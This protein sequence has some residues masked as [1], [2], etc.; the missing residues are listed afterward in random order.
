[1]RSAALLYLVVRAGVAGALTLAAVSTVATAAG[2]TLL[3]DGTPALAAVGSALEVELELRNDG[4]QPWQPSAG[5]AVSYHLLTADGATVEWDGVRTPLAAAVAVGDVARVRAELDVPA[6]AGEYRVVWD[7]VEEHVR[8][9]S[10]GDDTPQRGSPLTVR[11]QHAAAITAAAPRWLL[12]GRTAV[13]PVRVRN[14]GSFIWPSDGSVAVAYHWR[15]LDGTEVVWDGRRTP[16]PAAVAPGA[17]VSLAALV[18]APTEAG[19]LVLEW[20][21]VHEGVAWFSERDPEPRPQSVVRIV[22]PPPAVVVA[23]LLGTM[24]AVGLAGWGRRR[25]RAIGSDLVWLAVVTVTAPVWVVAAAGEH[26]SVTAWCLSSA[27]AALL[28]A[29]LVALPDGWRRWIVVIVGGA[30]L[31][32]AAGDV[33]HLRFFGDLPSFASVAAAGQ[34]DEVVASIASLLR[35]GDMWLAA[36][37]VGGVIIALVRPAAFSVRRRQRVAVLAAL[38]TASGITGSVLAMSRGGGAVLHQVFRNIYV[39]RELGTLPYHVVDGAR[40]AT[41]RWRRGHLDDARKA[42]LVGWFRRTMPRRAGAGASFGALAGANLVMIQVESLQTF[43]VG[44]E[45]GGEPVMPNLARWRHETVFAAGLT[46]QTAGGRSSDAELATQAS[47]LPPDRGT[48]V[49]RYAGNEFTG[50]AS[51]LS[52]HGYATL[53]AVPFDG[54]FW[55]RRNTHR[56]WGY[57]TTLFANAFGDGPTVGWGLNDRDFLLQAA[58]RI[59]VLERPFCAWLL[60]LS[61]HHPFEGFPERFKSLDV[62]ALDGTPFGNYLHTMHWLDGA[63]GGLVERLAE[64]GLEDTT[65]VAVWGDHDA[66]FEWTPSLAA[67]IGWPADPAGWYLSQTVPLFIRVPPGTVPPAALD[68]PAGHIDV[69][70]TLLALLGIDPAPYALVGRNLLGDPGTGPV[71]G[72]YRCWRDARRLFLQGGPQLGDGQCRLL[73]GLALLPVA[74]C[75]PGYRE[76][77]RRVEVSNLVLTHDLQGEVHR[78]LAA[79]PAAVRR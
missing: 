47:L 45:V 14:R 7:V 67:R 1:M 19:R 57:R 58:D 15:R 43:V 60:T 77:M 21:L 70:P 49:F 54:G 46:D 50:L 36:M 66:G 64:L 76:A 65:V 79:E 29:A 32:V 38:A 3:A 39:A 52:E 75:A 26:T 25:R 33:L 78:V 44:M 23:G 30:V 13:V 24:I 48:A 55:N 59:A 12:V 17:E 51:I 40:V 2:L 10:A 16:L 9:V 22:T 74:E 6:V 42:R 8:W 18:E 68:V 28:C 53:S 27:I 31:T 56:A 11:L 73:D 69:A 35:P 72:E 63:I 71:V 34:L 61:L 20:D 4:P 41:D 5:Y 62:G 37:A